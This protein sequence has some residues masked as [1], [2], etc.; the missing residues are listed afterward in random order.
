MASTDDL[1]VVHRAR[2]EPLSDEDVIA[3][4][5]S[6]EPLPDES[7]PGWHEEPYDLFDQAAL[8]IRHHSEN[9]EPVSFNDF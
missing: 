2:L 4:L 7:D 9:E 1:T 5:D 8:L 6:F 3:E